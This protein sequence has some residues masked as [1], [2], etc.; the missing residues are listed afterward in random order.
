[1]TGFLPNTSFP[2]AIRMTVQRAVT[3]QWND[4]TWTDH[5]VIDGCI[6]VPS[7]SVEEGATSTELAVTDRRTVYCPPGSDLLVTDRVILHPVG[8]D[9]IPAND[10]LRRSNAYNVLG[11]PTDWTNPLT[12]WSPGMEITLERVS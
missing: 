4:K 1:M 12:G 7:S 6:D 3:N 10:P 2:G 5:H 11:R 9:T 8:M